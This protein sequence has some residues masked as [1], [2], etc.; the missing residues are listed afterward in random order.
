MAA[1]IGLS[2]CPLLIWPYLFACLY[3]TLALSLTPASPCLRFIAVLEAK[4]GDGMS[5]T[6]LILL[7]SAEG[8]TTVCVV[9]DRGEDP[10]TVLNKVPTQGAYEAVSLAASQVTAYCRLSFSIHLLKLFLRID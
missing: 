6:V 4:D 10:T 5:H 2:F 8:Y 7:K 1:N 9:V 3:H